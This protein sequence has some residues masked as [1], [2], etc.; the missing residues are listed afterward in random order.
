VTGP[1][2]F[3]CGGAVFGISGPCAPVPLI[4]LRYDA[5]TD[6][7][8]TVSASAQHQIKISGYGQSPVPP[9]LTDLKVWTSVDGGTTWVAAPTTN[10]GGGNY[11]AT[12][13]VPPVSG[14]D[15]TVSVKVRAQDADGND[16][17]QVIIGAFGVTG[18]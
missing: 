7:T 13:H 18:R 15:G 4:F 17:T 14:T 1:G 11:I 10:R 9:T 3:L 8:G 2:A 5:G 12:Y 16:V 6:L